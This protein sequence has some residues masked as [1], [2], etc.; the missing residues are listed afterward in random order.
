MAK[1][2]QEREKSSCEY[3]TYQIPIAMNVHSVKMR[4][5][6]WKVRLLALAFNLSNKTGHNYFSR[7][8]QFEPIFI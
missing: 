1:C 3:H 6:N 2:K 8:N 4:G 7:S 5:K